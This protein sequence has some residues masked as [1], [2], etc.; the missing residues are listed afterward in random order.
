[1]N[2]FRASTGPRSDPPDLP[3]PVTA[4][5]DA[6]CEPFSSCDLA[7][8]KDV[9]GLGE[10]WAVTAGL[11][12]PR[13][14]RYRGQCEQGTVAGRLRLRVFDQNSCRSSTTRLVCRCRARRRLQTS[15]RR[16][17]DFQLEIRVQAV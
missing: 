5:T 6:A 1:V 16:M 3:P 15:F 13:M 14:R 12:D 11:V 17:Q 2:T 10:T 7:G 9:D 8:S 4:S